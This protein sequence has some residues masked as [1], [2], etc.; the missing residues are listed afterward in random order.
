MYKYD[1]ISN[2]KE[3][4]RKYIKYTNFHTQYPKRNIINIWGCAKVPFLLCCKRIVFCRKTP[5][6]KYKSVTAGTCLPSF[7]K[8]I[9]IIEGYAFFKFRWKKPQITKIKVFFY[10][11]IPRQHAYQVSRKSDQKV[12]VY[13]LFQISVEKSPQNTKSTLW[14]Y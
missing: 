2:N 4:T 8:S 10:G 5:N 13:T 11:D 1:H 6:I 14:Q 7:K 12:G 3:G 9:K